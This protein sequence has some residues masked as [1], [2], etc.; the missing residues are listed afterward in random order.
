MLKIK[1]CIGCVKLN[2]PDIAK[3]KRSEV[4][5]TRSNETLNICRK[6]HPIVEIYPSRRKSWSLNTM[7]T[8]VF[9]PE[10]ELSLFQFTKH[11]KIT[12]TFAKAFE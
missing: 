5:V 4:K 8:A 1:M 12:K 3:V 6:R 11:S 10:A 2:S 9:R 7:V